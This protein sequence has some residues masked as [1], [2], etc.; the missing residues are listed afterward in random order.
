ML[1][2]GWVGNCR[3][4]VAGSWH[5]AG[6]RNK[7]R[8]GEERGMP[9]DPNTPHSAQGERNGAC[10]A[11]QTHPAEQTGLGGGREG[12]ACTAILSRLVASTR[13]WAEMSA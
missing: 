12:S 9:G 8:G 6:R 13:I 11:A 1:W 4:G 5:G 2:T 7:G 10:L 3:G